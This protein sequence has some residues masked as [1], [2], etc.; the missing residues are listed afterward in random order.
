MRVISQDGKIDVPYENS[1]FYAELCA[2]FV[3]T[4]AISGAGVIGQYGSTEE[5]TEVLNMMLKHY[6]SIKESEFLGMEKAY[7]TQPFYILPKNICHEETN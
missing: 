2:V 1:V 7:F 5:A 3:R 6:C 4:P